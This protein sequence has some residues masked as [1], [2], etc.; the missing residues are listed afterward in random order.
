MDAAM[1]LTGAQ[2]LLTVLHPA[3]YRNIRARLPNNSWVTRNY[4]VGLFR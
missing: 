1:T 3:G 2:D 4:P